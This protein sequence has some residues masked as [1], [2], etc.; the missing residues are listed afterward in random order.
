MRLSASLS[1]MFTELPL[2]DRFEAAR[3]A[4]FEG[5]EIQRLSEGD[6][7]EMARAARAAGVQVALVNVGSGDYMTG[8]NGLSGVPG[9]EDEFRASF[10]AALEAARM[11]AAR[12]MH[13]GPSRIPDGID[14]KE[15]QSAYLANVRDALALSRASGTSLLIEAMNRVDAP[16]ALLCDNATAAGV[17]STIDNSRLGLQFDIYHTAMNGGDPLSEFERFRAV[18]RH[19]QFADAP[20]RHEPGTGRLNLPAILRAMADTGYSGWFGAEYR[21]LASTAASLRWMSELGERS[22]L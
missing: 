15:C 6:P 12:H 9:L 16:T 21:P 8:G 14:R 4:G 17:I 2:L 1:F 11:L 10:E 3:S 19:V 18:A 7:G 5:V 13:L 20:G 22:V